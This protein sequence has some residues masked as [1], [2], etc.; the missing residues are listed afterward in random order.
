VQGYESGEWLLAPGSPEPAARLLINQQ[1][2]GT[3]STGA[4][5][6]PEGYAEGRFQGESLATL[7]LNDV[8]FLA[9][10]RSASREITWTLAPVSGLDHPP[11][12]R[13]RLSAQIEIE[14]CH[15]SCGLHNNRRATLRKRP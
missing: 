4:E 5:K 14:E 3:V 9:A 15:G 13:A 1:I 10:T 7:S 12:F 6:P 8:S 2:T 11:Q